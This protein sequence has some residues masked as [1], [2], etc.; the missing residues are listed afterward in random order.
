MLRIELLGGYYELM[1]SQSK[2]E[3]FGCE[4]WQVI[5][6]KRLTEEFSKLNEFDLSILDFNKGKIVRYCLNRNAQN[7]MVLFLRV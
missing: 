2:W 1:I 6:L 3:L 4:K 7:I 5:K